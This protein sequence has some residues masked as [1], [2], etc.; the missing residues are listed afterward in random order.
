MSPRELRDIAPFHFH[1]TCSHCS[2][3]VDLN[4]KPDPDRRPPFVPRVSV[5]SALIFVPAALHCESIQRLMAPRCGTRGPNVIT[6]MMT[7]Y[8][9]L[10]EF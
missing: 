2:L 1:G 3:D 6:V 4:L 10:I 8:V 9:V 5:I 7:D